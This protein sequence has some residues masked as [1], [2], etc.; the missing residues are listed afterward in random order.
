MEYLRNPEHTAAVRILQ[1][2]L[3][4]VSGRRASGERTSRPWALTSPVFGMKNRSASTNSLEESRSLKRG[5]AASEEELGANASRRKVHTVWQPSGPGAD[6]RLEASFPQIRTNEQT[7]LNREARAA[8]RTISSEQSF[9][10]R[11]HALGRRPNAGR[12]CARPYRDRKLGLR[13]CQKLHPEI[14]LASSL[15]SFV[16]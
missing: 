14:V 16:G 12:V 6:Y 13:P 1:S 10:N 11:C 4:R 2:Q 9:G 3:Q 15:P 7:N 5:L 8:L